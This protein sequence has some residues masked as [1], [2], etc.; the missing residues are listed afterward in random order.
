MSII[1]VKCS[2]CGAPLEVDDS[3]AYGVC[4]YCGTKY[5]TGVGQAP[6]AERESID[7]FLAL[8]KIGDS[9]GAAALAREL[10]G[11]FPQKAFSWACLTRACCAQANES[12][13]RVEE[14]FSGLKIRDSRGR[15]VY[16]PLSGRSIRAH[17]TGGADRR[18]DERIR[19]IASDFYRAETSVRQAEQALANMR[20]FRKNGEDD[21]F[22]R[23]AEMLTSRARER[24]NSASILL[25][26]SAAAHAK[27]KKAATIV[28]VAA[29]ILAIIFNFL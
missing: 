3:S 29:V 19:S 25:D 27:G 24:C 18:A 15:D 23:D 11:R 6:S 10:A 17:G 28:V 22:C 16:F 14:Q 9:A 8:E 13:R 2:A 26:R 5:L 12:L 1:A 7:R 4:P 20:S 21:S